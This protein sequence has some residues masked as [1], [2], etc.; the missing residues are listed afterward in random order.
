MIG[1]CSLFLFVLLMAGPAQAQDARA[2]AALGRLEPEN[3]II[4]VSA[5]STPE[6]I[7]GG[8][9]AELHVAEVFPGH[10]SYIEHLSRHLSPEE[11]EEL[12]DLLKTLGKGIAD[13]DL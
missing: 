1:R 6:A 3:G 12:G 9:L 10:A 8:I 2:V 5:S 4:R 13:K 11:Q 7:L